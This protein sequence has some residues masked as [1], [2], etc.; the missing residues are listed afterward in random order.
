MKTKSLKESC[1]F[2]AILIFL[3]SLSHCSKNPGWPRFRGP[4]EMGFPQ[5]Q[6]GVRGR[7]KAAPR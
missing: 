5:K 4:R 1:V 7:W 2:L 3:L 6:N